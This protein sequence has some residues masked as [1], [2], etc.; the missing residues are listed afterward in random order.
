MFKFLQKYRESDVNTK[1]FI[2]TG[3]IYGIVVILTTLYAYG[4]LDFVRSYETN[5][6]TNKTQ[7]TE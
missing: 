5:N 7:T 6:Q 4:R 3:L 2:W 1:W